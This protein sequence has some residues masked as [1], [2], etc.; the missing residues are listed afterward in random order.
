MLDAKPEGNYRYLP[1]TGEIPFCSGVVADAGYEIVRATFESPVP[2]RRG[3]E[4]IDGHLKALERPRQ[5]LCGLELRCAAPYTREGFMEFNGRYGE[6]LSE[7]GLYGGKV[8]TGSTARTNIA[9]AYHA[10]A[11]QVMVAFAYTVPS[12]TSQ[13]TFIVSGA[14][15]MGV[16]QGAATA[17]DTREQVARIVDTLDERL[18]ELGVSWNLTTAF[19]AYAPFDIEPSL[20][21]EVVPKIGPAVLN[22]IRWFPGEAP[23]VGVGNEM[24]T[25]GVIQEIRVAVD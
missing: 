21:A 3:Y 17:D 15:A 9:P 16:A 5:A 23:V 12:S 7:W 11:E 13:P 18:K 1:S 2:W 25:Y 22:G 6:V 8:G 10:P 4:L 24:G 20:R 14:G 19:I